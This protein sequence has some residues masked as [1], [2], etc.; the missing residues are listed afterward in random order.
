MLPHT[1][2]GS[3]V[4]LDGGGTLDISPAEEGLWDEFCRTLG[5]A[6][7]QVAE[8]NRPLFVRALTRAANG[9]VIALASLRRKAPTE[10]DNG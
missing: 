9:Y 5:P 2:H 1:A 7:S 6:W 8:Q 10:P 3:C 4:P